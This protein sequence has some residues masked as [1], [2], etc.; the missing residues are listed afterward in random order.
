[1]ASRHKLIVVEEVTLAAAF[2]LL[3]AGIGATNFAPQQSYRFWIWLTVFFAAAGTLLG[4]V[5][6]WHRHQARREILALLFRQLVHW[7]AVFVTIICVYMLLK[8]GRLNYETTGLVT[9]LVLGLGV[10]LDGF[11]WVGWRYAL[12]GLVIVIT[13]ITAAFVEEYMWL[14]FL[15]VAL[16]WLLTYLWERHRVRVAKAKTAD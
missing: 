11:H 2:L 10:F 1:M 5:K 3:L 15:F 8:A 9:A 13:T 6:A 12:L 4:L 14:L 7:G 16:L